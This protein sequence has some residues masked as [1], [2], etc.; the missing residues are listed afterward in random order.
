MNTIYEHA[1]VV[2]VARLRGVELV[3]EVALL[4]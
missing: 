2:G 3:E 1:Y 4:R